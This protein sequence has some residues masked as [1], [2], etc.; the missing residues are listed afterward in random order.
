MNVLFAF[1][2]TGGGHRSATV[3]IIAALEKLSDGAVHCEMVDGLRATGFPILHQAPDLY[4]KL[5]TRW[6]PFYNMLYKIT[7]S[8]KRITALAHLVFWWSQYPVLRA[9]LAAQPQVVVSPHPLLQHLLCLTRRSYCLSFRI[10]TVVTDLVSIHSA[11]THPEVDL[12]LLPTDEAYEIIRRRGIPTERMEHTGFPVHPKFAHYPHSQAEARR[13][14]GVCEACT[15]ILVT[16]G[17]VGAG[18]MNDLVLKLEQTYP[19]KQLLVVTGQN[20]ALYASLTSGP[21]NKRTIVYGFV[22]NMESLMAASDIV[23]TKA[24]PGTLMEALVMR[25]PVIITEAI[26]PQ[27]EGNID[28]VVNRKLGFF[29]PT[30]EQIIQAINALSDE[31]SY[32]ETVARLENAVPS[33]GAEQIAT[34]LLK[35]LQP[36]SASARLIP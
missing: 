14:L 29:C 35:F 20:H 5:S 9:V 8:Q 21:R 19:E 13:A 34:I 3:A 31:R 12:H 10:V 28:F 23:V 6:L 11:W 26:G 18:H 2:D 30:D 33:D 4:K 36:F 1:S 16:S 15:T 22:N 7:N 32:A 25:R 27:E 17:G 24:G